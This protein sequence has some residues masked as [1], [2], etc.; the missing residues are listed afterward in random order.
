MLPSLGFKYSKVY[1][2]IGETKAMHLK[3]MLKDFLPDYA[4][5]H[6]TENLEENGTTIP[7]V[8]FNDWTP[9]GE[10]IDSYT[11]NGKRFEIWCAS[12]ADA[13]AKELLRRSQILIPLFIEGGTCQNLDN[14]PWTMERWKL[15]LLYQKDEIPSSPAASPYTFAGLATSYRLW[16]GLYPRVEVDPTNS[17][18]LPSGAALED[19]G[20]SFE[21]SDP[22]DTDEST[23]TLKVTHNPLNSRSRERISQFVILPPFQG[24]SHGAHL[25]NSMYERF[26]SDPAVFEIVVE[27][28]NESFDDLRDWCDLA[29]LRNN[30]PQFNALQIAD[31]VDDALLQPTSFVP[32][33]HLLPSSGTEHLR[34]EA[35]IGTRQFARLT[36]MH[37]LSKI[38]SL[39]RNPKRISRKAKAADENDRRFYFWRLLVKERIFRQH[40]GQLAQVDAEERVEKVEATLPG[41]Q[42]E[43]ERILKGAERRMKLADANGNV[44]SESDK[45][46][47]LADRKKKVFVIEDD[48]DD[49]DDEDESTT[50]ETE[51]K[52]PR[53]Q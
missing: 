33:D 17:E 37:L 43:Y 47:K 53:I 4:I 11:R 15:F 52:R 48:D 30:L 10:L 1:Q 16:V 7:T 41:I 18:D 23:G 50:I 38:P 24:Q 28:P 8:D 44:Q 45:K 14:E 6:A 19:D 46:R 36:E 31:R 20:D 49:D 9:P 26:K 21:D 2:P 12:L 40:L 34:K 42:E 3:E 25:Y 51:P 5:E 35:K 29:Y 39:N 13:K 22:I 27:D 32:V